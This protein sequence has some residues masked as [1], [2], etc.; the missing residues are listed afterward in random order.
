MKCHG[1]GKEMVNTVGGC[2]HC[3][4]CGLGIHD[5][6]YRPPEIPEI[7]HFSGVRP[8]TMDR[9]VNGVSVRETLKELENAY[10]VLGKAIKLMKEM[11]E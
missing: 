5:G 6:V 2:Y 3:P 7:L 8:N 9:I 4:H 10:E 11:V 1:C